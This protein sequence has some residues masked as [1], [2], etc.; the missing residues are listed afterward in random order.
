MV[1]E[2]KKFDLTN[3]VLAKAFFYLCVDEKICQ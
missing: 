3:K 2:E 1:A